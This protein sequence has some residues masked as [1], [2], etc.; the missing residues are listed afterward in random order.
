MVCQGHKLQGERRRKNCQREVSFFPLSSRG[1]TPR[2]IS[3]CVYEEEQN[4]FW[5]EAA[6]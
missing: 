4:I 5:I 3:V 1:F 2:Q 6:N